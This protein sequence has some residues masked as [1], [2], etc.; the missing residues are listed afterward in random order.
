MAVWSGSSG[1]ARQER[2]L[3]YDLTIAPTGSGPTTVSVTGD[4]DAS[5]GDRLRRAILDAAHNV[6]GAHVEVD[7]AGVTFMDSIG[8]RALADA[9]LVLESSG[10]RLV[11]CNV[12]RQVWRILKI[13]DIGRA[14]EVRT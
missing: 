7:L 12:P 14:L 5:N 10:S 2:T 3:H 13:T 11:L 6:A 4:V 9:S 1:S 8:I